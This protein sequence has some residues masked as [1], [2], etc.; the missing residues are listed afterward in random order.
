M[1]IPPD[2][3]KSLIISRQEWAAADLTGKYHLPSRRGNNY[4]LITNHK[5]YIKLEPMKSRDSSSY[6][7]AFKRTLDFFKERHHPVVFLVLDNETSADLK[8]FF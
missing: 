8:A 3:S 6:M 2:A 4:V 1:D 5:G 7:A